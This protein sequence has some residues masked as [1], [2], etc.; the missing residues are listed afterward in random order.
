MEMTEE[1]REDR[2]NRPW[3]ARHERILFLVFRLLVG[4]VF[5]AASLDK[6]LHPDVFARAVANYRILPE[7]FVNLFA[8]WLPWLE[9]ACGVLLLAGQWVRTASSIVAAL[10]ATF[11]AAVAISLVRGLDISCGCFG[12]VASRNVDL[13]LLLE[14]VLWL[15]MTLVLVLRTGDRL[16]WQ[17]F[18]GRV[19]RSGERGSSAR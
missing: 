2:G 16:G 7:P 13:E 9:F 6:I 14:D 11:I 3:L 8:V 4:G 17:P 18:L 1:P 5:V 12:N 15:S 19:Y 10:L